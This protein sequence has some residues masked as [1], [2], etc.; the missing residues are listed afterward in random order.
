M[1]HSSWQWASTCLCRPL[2]KHTYT[3][4]FTTGN[5]LWPCNEY[6]HPLNLWLPASV[7]Y[8]LYLYLLDDLQRVDMALGWDHQQ[9][10]RNVVRRCTCKPIVTD[11]KGIKK[12]W[13][14]WLIVRSIVLV[15]VKRMFS[16]FENPDLSVKLYL[17]IKL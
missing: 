2:H 7:L 8:K 15:Y 13:I 3:Q 5:I 1:F 6:K 17:C 16:A 4:Y 10:G 11:Y 14:L 12:V 9:L